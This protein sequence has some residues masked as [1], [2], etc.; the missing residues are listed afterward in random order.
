M[1]LSGKEIQKRLGTDI[2]IEPFNEKQLNPNSY[3]LRLHNE[4]LVYDDMYTL[5][6]KKDN[7]TKKIIIPEDGLLL[8]PGELYLGRCVEQIG[9]GNICAKVEGRSSV[10]RL[11][12]AV[13]VTATIIDQ[14]FGFAPHTPSYITLEVF[15]IRP[16]RIYPW[17]E[18]CQIIFDE[19]R[20]EYIPYNGKYQSNN[21][22]QVSMMYK[23]FQK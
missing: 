21:D 15:C 12:I 20:G 5:D 9:I 16:V 22:T 17:V 18:L 7:K 4:L 19:V 8:E 23:D 2:I 1:I 14:G 11:G 13:H 3:N 10:G 6:M